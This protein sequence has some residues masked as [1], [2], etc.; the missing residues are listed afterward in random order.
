VDISHHLQV[1][2]GVVEATEEYRPLPVVIRTVKKAGH[3]LSKQDSQKF[4]MMF[5]RSIKI[6]FT[7]GAASEQLKILRRAEQARAA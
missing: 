5:G 1:L 6:Q 3:S 7:D 4:L 2:R